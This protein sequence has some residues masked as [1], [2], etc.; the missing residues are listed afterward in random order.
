MTHQVG[1][2]FDD[3]MIQLEFCAVPKKKHVVQRSDRVTR[4]IL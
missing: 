3:C 1:E 4:S 2:I